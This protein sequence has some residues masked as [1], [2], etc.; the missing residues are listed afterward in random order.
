MLLI[1]NLLQNTG[2]GCFIFGMHGPWYLLSPP[3]EIGIGAEN[4]LRL[5]GVKAIIEL[6]L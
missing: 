4:G 1:L 6:Y 3:I 5:I 2:G